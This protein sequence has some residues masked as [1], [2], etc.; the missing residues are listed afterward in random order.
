M[1]TD[2]HHPRSTIYMRLTS[3]GRETQIMFPP[4]QRGRDRALPRDGDLFDAPPVLA[5]SHD[6]RSAAVTQPSRETG[7]GGAEV[8]Q[9]WDIRGCRGQL[10]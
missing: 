1:I 4:P 7:S 6:Q 9:K 3:G 2:H 5:R 8:N 10:G